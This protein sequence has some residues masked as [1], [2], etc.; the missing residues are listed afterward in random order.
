VLLFL[1]GG[2]LGLLVARWTLKALLAFSVSAGYVPDRMAVTVDGR[3][4]AFSVIVSLI[5]GVISGIAPALQA[6][7]V[8]LTTTSRASSPADSGGVRRTRAKQWLI[9]A[10]IA[11]SFVLLVGSGLMIR[12]VLALQATPGGIDARNLL[13]TASD[14]GRSFA[15]AVSYW[16][17][18]L[19]RAREFPGVQDV[20]F[21]SRPPLHG[22]R[23]QAFAIDTASGAGAAAAVAAGDVMISADYFRTMGIR[24]LKGRAFSETDG[25]TA[26]PVVIISESLARRYFPDRDP[27]G[28]RLSLQEQGPMGCCSAAGS[29]EHVWREIVGVVAD[30]R[31]GNLDEAPALTIYRPYT[32][33]VE[34]DMFLMVRTR[35]AADASLGAAQLRAHLAAIDPAKEWA[36]V[37]LM[38][39][40]IDGSES[41]RLRRFVLI[42]LAGFAG[43]ALLLAA[44][45]TY[46]VMAYAVAGRTREIGIRIALGATRPAVLRDVLGDAIR[47]AAA[48]LLLGAVI[49]RFSTRSLAS[50]LFAVTPLDATTYLGAALLLVGVAILASYVPARR[51]I[52][53]DPLIALRHE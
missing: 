35:S 32:Q 39:D 17:A 28:H 52:R 49:A 43:L 4:L 30:V 45:G 1:L 53:I 50:L 7:R 34:H 14:G 46:G 26:P 41:L 22:V 2:A 27:L 19:A 20:A 18:A 3:V 44:V 10:E 42:L 37:R 13:I 51:A 8:D 36:S 12:S 29:V 47:L 6:S 24:L 40:A 11:V 16:R 15:T 5:A 21:T 33:I 31:Q 9:I 23:Q 25:G 38:Q 48:G